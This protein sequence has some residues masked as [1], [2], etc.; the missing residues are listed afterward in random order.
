MIRP[1]RMME[2]SDRRRETP[3]CATSVVP[4][5]WNELMTS[6]TD[7]SFEAWTLSRAENWGWAITNVTA[8]EMIPITLVTTSAGRNM[9]RGL[10]RSASNAPLMISMTPSGRRGMMPGLGARKEGLCARYGPVDPWAGARLWDA[11]VRASPG[12]GMPGRSHARPSAGSAPS[13][14]SGACGC[15]DGGCHD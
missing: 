7:G 5:V 6:S 10:A 3:D 2:A 1:V 9:A 12:D 15:S 4:V 11:P 14:L 8:A 13:V